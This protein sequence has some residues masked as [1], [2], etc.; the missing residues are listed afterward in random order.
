MPK[1]KTVDHVAIYTKAAGH[2]PVPTK[3]MKIHL[4]IKRKK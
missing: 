1:V 3:E 2:P 4:D